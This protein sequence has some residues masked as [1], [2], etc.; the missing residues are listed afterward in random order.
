MLDM[1]FDFGFGGEVGGNSERM[2]L[3]SIRLRTAREFHGIR[4]RPMGTAGQRDG[5]MRIDLESQ[6]MEDRGHHIGGSVGRSAGTAPIGSLAPMARPPCTPP[7]QSRRCK[8]LRPVIAAT[9]W[10]DFRCSTELGQVADHGIFEHSSLEKIFDECRVTLIV[11]GCHDVLH[12][13]TE[14]KG[15]VP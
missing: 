6:A 13:S 1:S 4:H 15:F 2:L 12:P 9:G 8:A 10:I 11:H 7:R 5:Q 14:V 3:S